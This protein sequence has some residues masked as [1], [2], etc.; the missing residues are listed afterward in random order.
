MLEAQELIHKTALKLEL[1]ERKETLEAEGKR[2][3]GEVKALKIAAHNEQVD[4]ENLKSPSIKGLILS[5]TG[6]KQEKL[7]QEQAEARDAQQ[8]YELAVAKQ[9]AV[10]HKLREC[11][12]ELA[13]L[14]DCEGSLRALISFPEDPALTLL[15]ESGA[16]LS[17]IREEITKLI[18]ALGRMSSIG[19]FR[20]GAV[21]GAVIAG[22]NDSLMASEGNAQRMLIEV[23][24]DLKRLAGNLAVFGI[25][26]ETGSLEQFQDDYLMDLYTDAIITLRAEKVTVA[27]RQMGFRLDAAK[28]KLARLAQDQTKKHL[29]EV[30][31]AARS[32]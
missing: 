5:I 12:E 22:M 9:A 32:R 8:R 11:T 28:P 1:L 25:E 18:A 24:G 26:I 15:A 27:L 6:K 10:Q 3:D 31:D 17:Q 21:P 13:A 2:L 19:S 16:M 7:E 14:G 4:V 20:G 23:K 29:Q 30:L